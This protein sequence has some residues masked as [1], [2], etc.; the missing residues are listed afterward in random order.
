MRNR[1]TLDLRVYL[2]RHLAGAQLLVVNTYRDV[3][4]DRA[5]NCTLSTPCLAARGRPSAVEH[6][7]LE[8][9]TRR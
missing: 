1:G 3:E 9:D 7:S 5:L 2:A 4:V 6:H 8:G